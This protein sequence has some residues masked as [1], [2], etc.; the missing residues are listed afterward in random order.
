[1]MRTG[2][3]ER[4]PGVEGNIAHAANAIAALNAAHQQAGHGCRRPRRPAAARQRRGD[5]AGAES[6]TGSPRKIPGGEKSATRGCGLGRRSARVDR[7]AERRTAP[8]RE[9]L[10]VAQR[11][12]FE[13]REAPGAEPPRRDAG[14]NQARWANGA[15]A[16]RPRS[17]AGR[18]RRRAWRSAT[19]RSR[20]SSTTPT[21]RR[22][23]CAR[24]RASGQRPLDA[25][26]LA[27]D[28]LRDTANGDRRG[29]D[30]A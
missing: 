17:W 5:A 11:G 16:W 28:A 26:I 21:E 18:G 4:R 3:G 7:P 27:T 22:R 12:L 29:G 9:R 15:S 1:M 24:R 30:G 10:T 25:E 23:A 8:G 13:A 2:A 6:E 19:R 20:R 14:A